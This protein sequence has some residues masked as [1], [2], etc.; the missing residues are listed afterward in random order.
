MSEDSERESLVEDTPRL[1]REGKKIKLLNAGRIWVFV[2]K[3]TQLLGDSSLQEANSDS[4][5]FLG[6]LPDEAGLVIDLK[7]VGYVSSAAMGWFF[8]VRKRCSER[9]IELNLCNLS[10]PTKEVFKITGLHELFRIHETQ[11]DAIAS[12]NTA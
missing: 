5:Q 2:L 8:M 10:L 9:K 12:L 11:S 6:D 7:H 1:V 3:E 4:I